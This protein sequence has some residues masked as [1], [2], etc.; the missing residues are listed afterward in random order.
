MSAKMDLIR[1]RHSVRQYL[2][3]VIP[4]EIWKQLDDYAEE[5]NQEGVARLATE[6]GARRGARRAPGIRFGSGS[7][8]YFYKVLHS[9]LRFSQMDSLYTAGG[10]SRDN[11][12]I[13]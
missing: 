4:D 11:S 5:L 10:Y 1:Q 12:I 9:R 13:P 6:L 8:V 2:D 7:Q 3:K